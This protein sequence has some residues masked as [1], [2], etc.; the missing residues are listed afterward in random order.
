MPRLPG[1]GARSTTKYTLVVI[2]IANSAV[3]PRDHD[4]DGV[5]AQP[6]TFWSEFCLCK[7]QPA[8]KRTISLSSAMKTSSQT[9]KA[10]AICEP[11]RTLD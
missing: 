2:V 10:V 7:H 9:A 6:E 5:D 11:A 8:E 1:T 3:W 4:D